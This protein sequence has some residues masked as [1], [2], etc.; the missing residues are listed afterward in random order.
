M[1][2][3][4]RPIQHVFCVCLCFLV[5]VRHAPCVEWSGTGSVEH[6]RALLCCREDIFKEIDLLCG[7][8]H[9]NVIYLKEYFEEGNKVR[10]VAA[11]AC[12]H[13]VTEHMRCVQSSPRAVELAFPCVLRRGLCHARQCSWCAQLPGQTHTAGNPFSTP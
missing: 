13:Q 9:E 2:S 8:N 7:M 1:R 4:V 3:L 5:D 11:R 10:P 6:Q 12:L